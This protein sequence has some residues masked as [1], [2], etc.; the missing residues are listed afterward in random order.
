MEQ[1]PKHLEKYAP[2]NEKL[3]KKGGREEN[4]AL[5]AEWSSCP[6]KFGIRRSTPHHKKRGEKKEKIWH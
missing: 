1:L 2:H 5:V 4:L 3:K 6:R